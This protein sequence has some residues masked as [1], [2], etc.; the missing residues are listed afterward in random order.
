MN[1]VVLPNPELYFS[2][3]KITLTNIVSQ[4]AAA[5][6]D[7]YNTLKGKLKD[8]VSEILTI[9][10]NLGDA[11]KKL[12]DDEVKKALEQMDG[13]QKWANDMNDMKEKAVDEALKRFNTV[14]DA[15]LNIVERIKD[16]VASVNAFINEKQDKLTKENFNNHLE[17]L[18]ASLKN[19]L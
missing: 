2:S 4:L 19:R 15:V 3:L 8:K 6:I 10:N 7:S 11:L 12:K 5:F 18:K 13:W 1:D 17:E 9:A 14:K 16:L